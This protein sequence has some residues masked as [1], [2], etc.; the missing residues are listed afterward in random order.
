MAVTQA[1]LSADTGE[2]YDAL[3]G[4]TTAA[5]AILERAEN[6]VKLQA[7]TTTGQDAVI[8]PL[9]DAMIVNQAIGGVDSVNKTI[10]AISVGNKN[11]SVMQRFFFNEAKKASVIGGISLDGLK[12]ILKDSED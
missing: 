12:I 8:R 9:A 10:G 1:Q 4:G 11:L 5:A 7:G 2:I 6:F 3:D